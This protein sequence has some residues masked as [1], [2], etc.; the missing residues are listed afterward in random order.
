[1]IEKMNKTAKEQKTETRPG[2]EF[3]LN[4]P[5][6]KILHRVLQ[7]LK[8]ATESQVRKRLKRK[9]LD[10]RIGEL[11]VEL[12]NLKRVDLEK[13]LAIQ[14][15]ILSSKFGVPY[16]DVISKEL[17]N[18]AIGLVSLT[19]YCLYA[20]L[21]IRRE[22]ESVPVTFGENM[23]EQTLRTTK[24]TLGANIAPAV[25]LETAINHAILP[26]DNS[27]LFFSFKF[28]GENNLLSKCD[29]LFEDHKKSRKRF[30]PNGPAIPES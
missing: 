19:E 15:E 23:N 10:E 7:D 18:E 27:G 8:Y 9:T 5:S 3:G 28:H 22:G 17:D 1:M 21:P 29:I 11:L 20:F 25:A 26:K 14:G 16:L 2:L 6:Y 12:G 13:A 4:L 30:P 24:R